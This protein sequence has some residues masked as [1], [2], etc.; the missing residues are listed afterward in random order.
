MKKIY[1]VSIGLCALG[2]WLVG[3]SL[4]I[5]LYQFITGIVGMTITQVGII[6]PY[7]GSRE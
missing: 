4:N 2:G 5:D 6:L 3:R 7:Y 1:L